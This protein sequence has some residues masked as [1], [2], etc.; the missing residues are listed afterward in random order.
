MNVTVRAPSRLHFGLLHVPTHAEGEAA[1]LQPGLRRFGGLGLMVDQPGLTVHVQPAT[2]WHAQGVFSER[3]LEF[4]QQVVHALPGNREQAYHIEIHSEAREHTGLGIGTQLGLA[5]A[6]AITCFRCPGEILTSSDLARL[7]QRGKR[8]AIGMIGHE[9]GGLIVDGGQGAEGTCG[10]PLWRGEL[11]PE[12]RV[13]ILDPESPATWFGHNER[14]AFARRRNPDQFLGCTERMCRHLLLGVLPA[15]MERDFPN[16][17]MAIHAY[18]REAGEM[19]RADQGGVYSCQATADL[20]AW[21]IQQGI[22]G[23]GQSSWGPC[24]FAFVDSPGRA[25]HLRQAILA[26][27]LG[28]RTVWVARCASGATVQKSEEP[29]NSMNRTDE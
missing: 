27:Q 15:V 11:P 20:V 5:V 18:N 24:V 4:A 14:A 29:L 3:A 16:F 28:I 7:V 6:R 13:L 21:L 23:V 1:P 19:F 8:S 22:H 25:E 17:A 9:R 12:W 26:A 2:E 10:I